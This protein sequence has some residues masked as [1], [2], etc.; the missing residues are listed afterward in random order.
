MRP[1]WTAVNPFI[2]EYLALLRQVSGWKELEAL[3]RWFWHRSDEV[4]ATANAI[5]HSLNL[6]DAQQL[7]PDLP[8]LAIGGL[9]G[10][11]LLSANP[12]WRK[13]LNTLEDA[14][15]RQSPGAYVQLMRRFFKLHP[16][17][18]GERVSWWNSAIPW[19]KLLPGWESRFGSFQAGARWERADQTGLIGGWE[20]FPFHSDKDGLSGLMDEV[21]W[22]RQCALESVRA[23][24]RVSPE[25]LF[26]ASKRGWQLTRMDLL[27]NES[28]RDSTIGTGRYRTRISYARVEGKVEVISVARQV[29]SAPRNFTNEDL[30]NELDQLRQTT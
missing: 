19:V 16:G 15:C 17:V 24:I 28:W 9:T 10:V 6:A 14:Y 11:L 29:F 8:C 13:D 30:L 27:A 22:L 26:I 12:G 1:T 25:V 23:A 2:E 4:A 21:P 18:V 3:Y 7:Q 5:N 20:L